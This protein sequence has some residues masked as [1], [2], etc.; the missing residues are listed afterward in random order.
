MATKTSKAKG[1]AKKAGA[2]KT[3]AKKAQAKKPT[4]N[5]AAPKKAAPAKKTAKADAGCAFY[6]Y[7]EGQKKFV[8]AEQAKAVKIGGFDAFSFFLHKSADGKGWTISEATSGARIAVGRTQAEVKA[9]AAEA[10][11]KHGADDLAESI[12]RTIA[13][14]GAAPGF[15]APKGASKKQTFAVTTDDGTEVEVTFDAE[16]RNHLEFRGAVSP[17]GYRSHFGYDGK[18]KVEDAARKIANDLHAE[19]LKEQAKQARKGKK[20]AEAQKAPQVTTRLKSRILAALV[21]DKKLPR[22]QVQFDDIVKATGG[23]VG[24][25]AAALMALELEHKIKSLPGKFYR[26]PKAD[27]DTVA[28]D[29]RGGKPRG[30]MSMLDAAV[31]VLKAAKEPLTVKDITRAVFEKGLAATNGRTPHATLSAAMGR[32]IKA[33]GAQSRFRRADRG[34]FELNA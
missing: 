8:P 22:K 12:R 2:K 14:N 24:D 1:A 13:K 34:R 19:F 30:K 6:L 21:D 28:K 25:V 16:F 10:L 26:L 31:E 11:S 32:E 7:D 33:R 18:G 17:T 20:S 4:D 15:D 27:E 23:E 9:K 5:K 29:N 3:S